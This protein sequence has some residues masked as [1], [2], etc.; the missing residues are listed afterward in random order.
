MRFNARNYAQAYLD[1]AEHASAHELTAITKRFAAVLARKR[2]TRH[3]KAI[4]I[5]LQSLIDERAGLHRVRVTTA[6]A[7]EAA[8]LSVAL[9]SRAIIETRIDSA[10]I[11][12]AIIER[13]DER[14]DASV[15]T[16]LTHLKQR[17]T[18]RSN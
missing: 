6:T 5:A 11:G 3:K 17:L 4:L 13:G 15:R 12:G 1:L 9:G 16:G 18:R 2:L 8:T 10:L 7:V 14:I